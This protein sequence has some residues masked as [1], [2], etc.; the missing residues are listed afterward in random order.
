MPEA[1]A[2]TLSLLW[3]ASQRHDLGWLLE[4]FLAWPDNELAEGQTQGHSLVAGPPDLKASFFFRAGELFRGHWTQPSCFRFPDEEPDSSFS[5]GF[6]TSFLVGRA[7]SVSHAFPDVPFADYIAT[8]L[9]DGMLYTYCSE[10]HATVAPLQWGTGLVIWMVW[11]TGV[12]SDKSGN[13]WIGSA[14]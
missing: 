8:Q 12:Q 11:G 7:S 9:K 2:P 5:T 3:I 1:T 4:C 6:P 13:S 14:A 10:S